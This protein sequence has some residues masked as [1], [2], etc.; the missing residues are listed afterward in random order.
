MKNAIEKI[1]ILLENAN[2]V[3]ELQ[4]EFLAVYYK[5]LFPLVQFEEITGVKVPGLAFEEEDHWAPLRIEFQQGERSYQFHPDFG[6]KRSW[7]KNSGGR[8]DTH[9]PTLRNCVDDLESWLQG[10]MGVLLAELPAITKK[11]QEALEKIK[12]LRKLAY[13]K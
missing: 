12:K 1:A 3:E 5:V 8:C 11:N 6:M 7:E 13:S 4:E 10:V 9:L 2:E